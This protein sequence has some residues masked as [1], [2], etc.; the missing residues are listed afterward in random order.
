MA[1]KVRYAVDPED[2]YPENY[3]GEVRALLANGET[4]SA[5][6]PHL[7]GGRREPLSDQEIRAK[8][9]ANA[10][11]GGWPGSLARAYEGFCDEAF[12]L[13]SLAALEQFRH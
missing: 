4:V 11:F 9:R 13:P 5:R 1:A 6:Q 10:G 2:P 7:R 3:V 12:D 8:F